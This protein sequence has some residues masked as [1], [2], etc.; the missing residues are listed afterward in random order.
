M[1][2]RGQ[3]GD[4]RDE[5]HS[6]EGV[7][8]SP[9]LDGQVASHRMGRQRHAKLWGWLRL[10]ATLSTTWKGLSGLVYQSGDPGS[11]EWEKAGNN[12]GELRTEEK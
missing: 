8:P 2:D 7:V 5:T 1:A 12:H 11:S 10:N 6:R 3:C 4:L 9:L